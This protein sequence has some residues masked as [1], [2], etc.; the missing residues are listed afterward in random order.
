MAVSGEFETTAEKEKEGKEDRM[1]NKI[2]PSVS[3][4]NGDEQRKK[5]QKPQ[6][7]NGIIYSRVDVAHG[8]A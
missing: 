5:K 4:V 2:K 6:Y 3:I 8:L 7:I 1:R